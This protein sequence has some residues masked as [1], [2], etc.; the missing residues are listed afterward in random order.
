MSMW[1]AIM[2]G[3]N[4]MLHAVGWLEGGLSR[5]TRSSSST[6]RCCRPMAEFFTPPIV[7]DSTL[8]IDAIR[9]AGHGGH[10]FGAQHTMERYETA[11][12]TPLLSDWRNFQQWEAT[13]SVDATHRATK[14]WK[15]L[16]RTTKSRNSIRPSPK[17]WTPT[18]TAAP[19]KAARPMFEAADERGQIQMT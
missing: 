13:G 12:Y 19:A 5:P 14:I 17:R 4:M 10:F 8:A 11:F 1:G 18:S 15:Q 16:W 7:D 9:E 3:S 6:P 2:G